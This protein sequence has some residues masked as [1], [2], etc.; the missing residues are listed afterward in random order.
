M[1]KE[2][3]QDLVDLIFDWGYLGIFL[4]MT[5]ESSFIPF[6]SEIILIPAGY[7]AS[8]G[9]MSISMIMIAGVGGSIVGA[10]ITYY[11]ALLVFIKFLKNIN[12]LV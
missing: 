12:N 6:P 10:F 8:K 9:E 11:L 3:A 2:L 4:L 7:L 5:V 1:I